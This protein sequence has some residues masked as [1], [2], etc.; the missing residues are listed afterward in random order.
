MRYIKEMNFTLNAGSHT[1]LLGPNGA[2]KSLL[3]RLCHGLLQPT[4]GTIT[5][6]GPTGEKPKTHQ[7]M[8]FQKPVM[9]RRSVLA[10]LHFGLKSRGI[11]KDERGPII[12]KI[13]ETTGLS[14]L[15]AT[16]ARALSTGEQQRLAIGRAWSLSPEV[17]FLDEPTA[18]LDPAATHVVEEIIG[19]IKKSGTTI[20]MS[21]HDLGQA[22]RLADDI[23]FLYRGRILENSPAAQ[24][25]DAPQNDL[26]RSFLKGELLWWHRQKLKPP[27]EQKH[28]ILE[29]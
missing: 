4:D 29:K 14:R 15:S 5:W 23:L 16:P 1:I 25:F 2:G 13:L 28:R 19:T 18:N 27:S 6:R 26:A 9:L 21:T 7:A 11:A 3:L 20:V 12:D 22:K 10:N 24:F 17:L 8:V